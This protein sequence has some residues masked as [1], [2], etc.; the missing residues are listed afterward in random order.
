MSHFHKRICYDKD[1][2]YKIVSDDL[3]KNGIFTDDENEIAN[4]ITRKVKPKE[5]IEKSKNIYAFLEDLY[6]DIETYDWSKYDLT[7]LECAYC[8]VQA[9]FKRVKS[10]NQ[11]YDTDKITKLTNTRH[12][13]TEVYLNR[14]LDHIHRFLENP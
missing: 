2:N 11:K 13:L 6:G 9:A 4:D 14:I 5:D 12:V 3:Y 7:D 1:N 8:L 10:S